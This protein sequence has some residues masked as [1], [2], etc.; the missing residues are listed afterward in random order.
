[1]R[2]FLP[3]DDVFISTQKLQITVD[4]TTPYVYHEESY[5]G[6]VRKLQR[7]KGIAGINYYLTLTWNQITSSYQHNFIIRKDR[8][9]NLYLHGHTFYR[10]TKNVLNLK[11]ASSSQS[12]RLTGVNHASPVF[13]PVFPMQVNQASCAQEGNMN[14]EECQ[15]RHENVWT[16]SAQHDEHSAVASEE[17]D[18]P[19]NASV[20]LVTYNIWNFNSVLKHST[21]KF[22][23]ARIE[24]LG[25]VVSSSGADIIGFQ[26]VR[27][28]TSEKTVL[29]P[30]QVAH[31]AKHLPDYQVS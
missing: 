21:K 26:E 9:H 6:G 20:K 15:G 11:T 3:S 22:Y 16:E 18:Q 2:F 17:K 31:L 8:E 4:G 7:K 10:P 24:R 25:Q 29:G 30:S 12:D 1:M 19:L 27:F 28:D 13:V 23:E 5:E 14:L